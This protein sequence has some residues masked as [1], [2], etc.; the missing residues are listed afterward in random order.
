MTTRSARVAGFM[1]AALALA[2]CA[3]ESRQARLYSGVRLTGA[4]MEAL[5]GQTYYGQG[6]PDTRPIVHV[7]ASGELR[8]RS[9]LPNGALLLD[10]G[11]AQ[12]EGDLWCE[13]WSISR[14][15]RRV[16]LAVLREGGQLIFIAQ[17]ISARAVFV[18][19]KPGNPDNL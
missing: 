17:D 7:T 14:E 19:T 18:D 6:A 2:A 11:Q 13:Q 8:S 15:N 16:C 4:Q 5:K 12:I 9:Y 3:T 1:L 10:R